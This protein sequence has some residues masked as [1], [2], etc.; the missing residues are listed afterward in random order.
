[1]ES[2]TIYAFGER[3]GL[4]DERDKFF[5]FTPGNNI[6]DIHMNQGSSDRFMKYDGVWQDGG[7][8]IHLPD[9]NRWIA[10]FLAFQSQCFHT[11]DVE[12]YR[13][14]DI[15][16]KVPPKPTEKSICIIAAL[17]NPKGADK[18]L[19]SVTLLN[20]TPDKDRFNRLVLG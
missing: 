18:G 10:I 12:G 20:T 16:D 11:D 2:S 7:L 13:I 17:V 3:W 4:R 14:K 8:I 15:C 9:E 19:E 6:H 1:M 5:G